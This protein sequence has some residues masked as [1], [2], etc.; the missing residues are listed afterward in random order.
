MTVMHTPKPRTA[1][2][3]AWVVEDIPAGTFRVNRTTLIDEA[4][5]GDEQRAIFERCWLYIGHESEIPTPGDFRARHVCNRPLV[6]WHG[7]DAVR[8]VFSHSCRH[9]AARVC[10]APEA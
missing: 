3:T 7:Q 8:G 10:R 9:R 4:V 6:F 5:F 1:T 2:P